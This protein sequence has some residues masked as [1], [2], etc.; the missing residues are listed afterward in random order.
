MGCQVT[1]IVSLD[2]CEFLLASRSSRQ[3]EQNTLSAGLFPTNQLTKLTVFML[4]H[5][6]VFM[7]CHVHAA[8]PTSV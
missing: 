8:G 5:V 3:Y 2:Q 6:H 1:G 4:C 7:L